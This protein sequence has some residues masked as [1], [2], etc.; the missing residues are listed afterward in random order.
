MMMENISISPRNK[1]TYIRVINLSL[2]TPITIH[3]LHSIKYINNNQ[4]PF[5]L[6]K[7]PNKITSNFN[8]FYDIF[9]IIILISFHPVNI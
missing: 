2:S 7:Y 9:V 6:V 5:S 3:A 4:L 8:A 1:I